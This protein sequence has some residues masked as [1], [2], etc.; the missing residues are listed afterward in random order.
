MAEL[1]EAAATQHVERVAGLDR[2]GWRA[3]AEGWSTIRRFILVLLVL[4][5]VKQGIF[6][7]AFHPF[8]GHD[9]VAHYSYL[10]T[11]ATEHRVPIL[12]E[13][14]LPE[15]LYRYCRYVLNWDP[16]R[17]AD[18]RWLANPPN[19]ATYGAAGAH[20]VGM[21][22]A[23]N[24]PPLYYLLMTPL[25]WISDSQSAVVQQYLLRVAAI[26]FGLLTVFLAFRTVR[27]LFPGDAFLAVTVPAFVAF[28]PQVSY[29][30][31]MVNNDIVAIALYS[32]I[33]YLLVTGIRD[34]FPRRIS[35]LLGVAL[36]LALLSKGT[37][38][39]VLPIVALAVV[40]GL[41]WRNLRGWLSTGVM[42]AAIGGL[43]AFPWY[44][45]L[46]RT[47]GN[48][49]G[50]EQISKL[51]WWNYYRQ[52]KPGFFDLLFNPKFVADRF[53]ETW[54]QFGWRLIP[55][56]TALLWA[57]AIPLLVGAGGLVQYAVTARTRDDL[58]G[59]G[60]SVMRP[61]TWQVSALLVLLATAV[62]A[63][64]AVVQ[65]G[66]TFSLTQARYFFPAVNAGAILLMLGLR[67]VIPRSAHRYGQGAIFAA[68]V[69]LNVLVF[70][71]YVIPHYR[72]T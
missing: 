68:L 47:Y 31:A 49:D 54:G 36:G 65:F 64:L 59:D 35:V 18:T 16:C 2:E 9:E 7:V 70:T 3:R 53:A 19:W 41:G 14:R 29:E 50:F 13:D 27:A 1:V 17:P 32:W 71:Q 30:A 22:Y 60:D 28:Q 37:S 48:L 15:N 58:T 20:Q 69:L 55:L 33:L 57:I 61:A 44:L 46:W 25:Y 62:V 66:T 26:P 24:H 23:A 45:F 67:T 40:L 52:A 6:V 63:Y 5:I 8:S 12:L 72:A 34:R 39:T 21:Q 56:S 11:V 42:I 38:I 4:Y 43:I 10:Q 51:Q